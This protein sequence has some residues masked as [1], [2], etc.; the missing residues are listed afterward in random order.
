MPDPKLRELVL[1][2]GEADTFRGWAR[3]PKAAQAL[4]LRS[5]IVLACAGGWSNT[6]V[7]EGLGV[8]RGSV[9]K[10][11]SRFVADRL[12]GS[13]DEPRP[14]RPRTITDEQVEARHGVQVPR[15]PGPRTGARAGMTSA[16]S[17]TAA[18]SERDAARRIWGDQERPALAVGETLL[19]GREGSPSEMVVARGGMVPS[20]VSLTPMP[21]RAAAPT[22]SVPRC[23]ERP[24]THSPPR[25]ACDRAVTT[26]SESSIR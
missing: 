15:H 16:C 18:F 12:D 1:S 11:R 24:P 20:V 19:A 4:A 7:A 26:S 6:E 17:A 10:W 14:G 3:R 13:L 9:A 5:R 23:S 21:H 8:Q 22:S 25:S 2:E